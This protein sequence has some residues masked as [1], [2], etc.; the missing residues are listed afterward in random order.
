M[1]KSYNYNIID[2]NNQSIAL[3]HINQFKDLGVLVDEK[4]SCK[5]HIQDKINKAFSSDV[6]KDLRL[7]A[8]A[9]T[10]DW[11]FKD[12]A[13]TKDWTFKAK[14]RTK[15]Y[16]FVLKDNQGPRTKAKDNITAA[17]HVASV[18]LQHRSFVY[19]G[20]TLDLHTGVENIS[21][22][23]IDDQTRFLNAI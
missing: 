9:R 20:S 21:I 17:F 5:D 8:K 12:K 13:R 3:E 11:T 18:C 4:L 19:A 16:K 22:L 15:D 10:K 23:S 2:I 14:A 7:K 1:D 6:N